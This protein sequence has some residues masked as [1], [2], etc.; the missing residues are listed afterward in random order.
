[1]G[2]SS[3]IKKRTF[4]WKLRNSR[5][6]EQSK[7]EISIRSLCHITTNLPNN[8]QNTKK[9]QQPIK[10]T[11]TTKHSIGFCRDSSSLRIQPAPTSYNQK[12][13]WF[14]C[15]MVEADTPLDPSRQVPGKPH[16]PTSSAS[17]VKRVLPPKK[18]AYYENPSKSKRVDE[19][20]VYPFYT[21]NQLNLDCFFLGGWLKNESPEEKHKKKPRTR[22]FWCWSVVVSQ[23]G[24][25]YKVPIAPFPRLGIRKMPTS[26][27]LA[28]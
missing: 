17:L 8:K 20:V 15:L 21:I 1:M 24:K 12:H 18:E 14:P 19:A 22:F 11:E 2:L 6:F 26:M 16:I 4:K 25:R 13:P 23:L 5:S 28:A 10:D 7:T 3:S 27:T 9:H